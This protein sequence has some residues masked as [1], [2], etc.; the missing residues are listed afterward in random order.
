MCKSVLTQGPNKKSAKLT[1]VPCEEF[2]RACN[3]QRDLRLVEV[4]SFLRLGKRYIK[5]NT[6]SFNQ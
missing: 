3:L 5:L 6:H 2:R 1:I 4:T